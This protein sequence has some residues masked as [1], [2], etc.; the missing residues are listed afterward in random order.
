MRQLRQNVS[1]HRP[2]LPRLFFFLVLPLLAFREV[3]LDVQV[4]GELAE[5]PAE[6]ELAPDRPDGLGTG[7]RS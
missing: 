4:P 6:E 2:R 5:T 1:I 7:K 3:P